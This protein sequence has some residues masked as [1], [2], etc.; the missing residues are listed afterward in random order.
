MT[1]SANYA[2]TMKRRKT[3]HAH[4][5]LNEASYR[6][7]YAAA[8]GTCNSKMQPIRQDMQ[9]CKYSSVIQS[10]LIMGLYTTAHHLIF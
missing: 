6:S 1:S 7:E 2:E 4:K 9:T 10:I 8:L 3:A 5:P